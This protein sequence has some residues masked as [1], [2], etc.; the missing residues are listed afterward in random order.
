MKKN[1][2]FCTF[3]FLFSLSINSQV[4]VGE[5]TVVNTGVP[6]EPY[7]G[8]SYSQ[9]IYS[10]NQINAS[11]S[12]TGVSYSAT[13]GTTLATSGQWVVYVG[14]TDKEIF[15]STTDWI[16]ISELTQVYSATAE[17]PTTISEQGVVTITF[18][19]PF[20]YDGSLN[21]VIAVEENQ[22][23]YDSSGPDF[24]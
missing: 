6:I 18:D 1:Y 4:V 7:Y 21:L 9:S 8:Y 3:I 23:G 19:A 24:Y 2:I 5:G 17:A 16:P 13:E 10:S 15:E 14:L 12:I 20:E 22:D 11:G